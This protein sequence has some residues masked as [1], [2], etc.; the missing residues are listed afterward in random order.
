MPMVQEHR[1]KK[2]KRT[3]VFETA[4]DLLFRL[5]GI[6]A[7]RIRMQPEP[8]T[9]T[10]ADVIQLLD[11]VENRICELVDGTLVEKAV[12]A[13]ESMM[14]LLIAQ[15]I[16]NFI[17]IEDIG[18]CLGPD[19]GIRMLLGNIRFPDV[20]YIPWESFPTEEIET[21]SIW[22]TFPSLA[23]EVLSKSNTQREIDRKIGELFHGGTKLIWVIDP[24]LKI[25]TVYTSPT[26]SKRFTA[27]ESLDGGKVLPGFSL[28][29]AELF[30]S[31]KRK[32]KKGRSR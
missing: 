4:A 20:S 15:K 1:T 18:V 3:A 5:D 2:P 8:G 30:S 24:E 17:Q 12:G 9:A 28:S 27:T 13:R 31:T 22:R 10:E 6:P 16:L 23:V 7:D 29:L 32:K 14:A 11:S 26:K 25:A 21:G 19:G